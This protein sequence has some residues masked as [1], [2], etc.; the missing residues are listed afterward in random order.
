MTLQQ[1][2][3]VYVKVSHGASGSLWVLIKVTSIDLY[4]IPGI[5]VMALTLHLEEQC[6]H[7]RAQ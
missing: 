3:Q 6:Q 2:Q 5:L 7:I 1:Q 4:E